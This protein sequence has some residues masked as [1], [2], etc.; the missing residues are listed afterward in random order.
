MKQI[1]KITK[2]IDATSAGKVLFTLQQS[3]I[4]DTVHVSLATGEV[5]I[6]SSD[7]VS[8]QQI[9]DLLQEVKEITV[10]EKKLNNNIKN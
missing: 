1:F 7:A 10:E 9:K 8:V 4:F 3:G 2:K 5:E 6:E